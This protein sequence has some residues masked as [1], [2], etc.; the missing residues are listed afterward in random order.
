MRSSAKSIPEERKRT[1][2]IR[3]IRRRKRAR[4]MELIGSDEEVEDYHSE[5]S[6]D[7]VDQGGKEPEVIDLCDRD[8]DVSVSSST[9]LRDISL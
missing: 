5:G 2:S 7:D 8:S 6:V 1:A 4:M 3:T 9:H